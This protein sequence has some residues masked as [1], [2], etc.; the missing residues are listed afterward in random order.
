MISK[1][2]LSAWQVCTICVGAFGIQFGFALPQANATR[3]FQNLGASLESVPLLWLAGPITGLIIQPLVGYYSDRTWTRFGRRRPYFLMGAALAAVALFALTNAT[4]L[5]VAVLMLW[6]LDASLNLTMGPFRA[7]VAD[8]MPAEQRSTGYLMYMSFASVGAVV[9]SLLPWAF[10]QLGATSYAPAGEISDAVKYAFNVG[11]TLLLSAVCWSALTTREYPP[12]MLEQFD[13]AAPER[14]AGRSPANM[15][16]HAW[17]WLGL[18]SLGLLVAW[19]ANARAALYVLVCASLVYAGFLLMA[20]RLRSENAFTAILG[21][22]ES[23]PASMRRLAV[24][25][26]CSWFALFAIFVYTAP[27]VARM[28]FG[29][30]G[31][32]SVA[33]EAGANWAGVLFA[34]YNGLAAVAALIIPYFVRRFGLQMAHRINL[35]VGAAGLLSMLLIREA[36]WLLVSMIG[37]GFAWASIISLPYAMLANNLP[38]RRMG[39]NFGIFNIFIV[40]P[41]LLAVGVMASLLDV[42]ADGDPS[43]ALIIA[44]IG[45]FLAGLAVLRVRD[46]APRSARQT[47]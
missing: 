37:I 44:A 27:A 17:F 40:I 14:P 19:L 47:P 20:S 31:P 11:A 38:S 4:T 12:G 13:D 29:A 22:M 35:W 9:G 33:Y 46:P 26:F 41:Q 16:R 21:E 34:T 15:R 8:Q 18:G 7:F 1:P 6:I 42:F 5:W 43:F 23:M 36:E 32:G 45:W 24:V 39:V 2:H 28:H 25:Q 3:I 30:S 10:A